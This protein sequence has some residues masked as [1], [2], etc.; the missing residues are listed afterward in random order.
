MDFEQVALG[1]IKFRY[2]LLNLIAVVN[3]FA[4]MKQGVDER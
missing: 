4:S 1:K 2:S 3:R